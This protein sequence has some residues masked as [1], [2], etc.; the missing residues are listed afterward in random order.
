[1]PRANGDAQDERVLH[2]KCVFRTVGA[3]LG[4]I[5]VETTHPGGLG[6]DKY[7]KFAMLAGILRCVAPR[8]I[9]EP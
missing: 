5:R 1:M 9:T 3:E 4:L 7:V 2:E 6:P 8:L